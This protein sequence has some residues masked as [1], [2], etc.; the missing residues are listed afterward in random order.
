[1]QAQFERLAI[2]ASALALSAI[3]G[4]PSASAEPIATCTSDVI[5]GIEVDYCV[6]NPNANADTVTGVPGVNVDFEFGLG[7]GLG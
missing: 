7:I 5:D 6:G 1:M 2:A 3:V 4:A